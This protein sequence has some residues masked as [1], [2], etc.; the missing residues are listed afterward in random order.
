MPE[1]VKL[2]KLQRLPRAIVW[3][4]LVITFIPLWVVLI[5]CAIAW[6]YANDIGETVLGWS[7]RKYWR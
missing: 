7:K 3:W 2:T 6:N 1:H 4:Y 5:P